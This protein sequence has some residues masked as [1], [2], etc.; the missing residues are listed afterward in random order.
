MIAAI[1]HLA[2]LAEDG[3]D[4]YWW[5]ELVF[6]DVLWGILKV[7]FLVGVQ[8]TLAFGVIYLLYFLMTLPMRRNERARLFLDLL[9]LGLKEGV[10]PEKAIVDAASS[11]DRVLG[12]RFQ[13]LAAYLE[14]GMKFTEALAKVPRL[15]PA[16]L[17]AMLKTGER[18][19]DIA[20]VLP[21]C[22]KLL[23]DGISQ[24]RGAQNYS[25]ILLFA[26]TPFTVSIPLTL[27]I[28]VVPRFVQIFGELGGGQSLPAF[29]QFVVGNGR[30]IAEVQL[31]VIAFVWLLMFA[32][33]GGPRL[34]EWIRRLIPAV[35][36]GL[37]FRFPWRRKRLQR[38]FS[39]MLSVLLD[40]EVPEAEAVTLAA[41]ATDNGVI[42]RRAMKVC[43]LLNSGVKLPEAI[44]AV[45]DCPELGWRISNAL[46]GSGGFRRALTGWHESL[47]AKAF[48][49][50]QAVAQITTS[51]LVLFNGFVVAVILI[52]LFLALIDLLEKATLW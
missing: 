10:A 43:A 48:Q 2:M 21:A 12:V 8:I 35:P 14:S 19:G 42:R 37:L 28:L 1:G 51:A 3:L 5:L 16:Q 15:L 33:V 24:V 26:I 31:A 36:D 49:Q 7:L 27:H 23:E 29:T 34:L 41:D 46:H 13:L 6:G 30:V 17:V 39:S 50:E 9:E 45:D 32:Y 52:G 20:K 47:D 22:H 38:D 4:P 18:I 44:R 40:A 11:R 25:L